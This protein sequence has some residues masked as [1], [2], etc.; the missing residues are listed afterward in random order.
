MIRKDK[1]RVIHNALKLLAP[2]REYDLSDYDLICF[3][4]AEGGYT[5]IFSIN[6]LIY[7]ECFLDIPFEVTALFKLDK[8][9]DIEAGKVYNI[10]ERND[11]LR[12][13]IGTPCTDVDLYRATPIDKDLFK[14]I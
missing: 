12:S 4:G 2:D 9:S 10:I 5:Q 14:T 8:L 11:A 1:L 7:V 13:L 6:R 3:N